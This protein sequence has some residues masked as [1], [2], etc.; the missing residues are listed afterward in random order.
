MQQ[1]DQQAQSCHAVQN[2]VC[3]WLSTLLLQI[4]MHS[5]LFIFFTQV[6]EELPEVCTLVHIS[7]VFLASFF[8]EY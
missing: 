1:T 8:D 7:Q 2:T 5:F 3:P 6:D 4:H